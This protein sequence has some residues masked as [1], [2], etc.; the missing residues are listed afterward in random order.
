[1]L[2]DLIQAL[3]AA[4]VV[5]VIPGYPWSRVLRA[6]DDIV[7]QL[8]YA[9]G[10]SILLVPAVALAQARL[11]SIGLSFTVAIV[12][13][14]L[15]TIGGVVAYVTLGP[16]KGPAEHLAPPPKPLEL[17][18]LAPLL[19]ALV[20]TLGAVTHLILDRLVLPVIL[21]LILAA[22]AARLFERQL[23]EARE[24]TPLDADDNSVAGSLPARLDRVFG[25]GWLKYGL[26]A[27]AFGLVAVRSYSGPLRYDWPYL[28]GVDQFEHVVMTNMTIAT[29]T[30]GSFM[31]YPPGFHY[32]TALIKHFS[33][34]ETM[35]IYPVLGPILLPLVALACYAVARSL[36]GWGVGLGAVLLVGVISYGPYMHFTEARYP[37]MLTGHFI[38]VLA[39]G[40]LFALFA[41]PNRRT[42]ILMALMGSAVVLY[43]Q[44]ASLHEAILLGVITLCLL[45]YLLIHDRRRGVAIVGS[46]ALLGV[47]AVIFAWNTYD[48]PAI[49]GSALGISESGRGGDALS[50]AI[51]TQAPMSLIHQLATISHPVMW[52][53]LLG[54]FLLL[55]DRGNLPYTLARVTLLLWTLMVLVGS[56]T[57]MSGFPERFERDLAIPLSLLAAYALLTLLRSLVPLRMSF[58]TLAAFGAAL[59]ISATL[60]A[61]ANRNFD[62]ASG[63]SSE[64]PQILITRS[65]QVILS[66]NIE[67]AGDW[68]RANND[69]GNILAS[70]YI[71]IIP[72]RGILAMGG[73]DGVQS[74]DAA[75]IVFARDLPPFGA[76]PLEKALATLE[77]P[78]ASESLQFIRENDI[79]YV[80]VHKRPAGELLDF[81]E[82]EAL[83]KLYKSVYQNPRVAIYEPLFT[84]EES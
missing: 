2:G 48:L 42:G 47:L 12:S 70:P 37:N 18:T 50:M 14:L 29:G 16:A 77:N 33:G 35:A 27:V 31:L 15:V 13:V 7:E 58:G 83:E 49:V 9:V 38:L 63:P 40:A 8:A 39:M 84:G 20:L 22:G 56:R 79:R 65:A 57:A 6:T 64:I 19:A 24:Q 11:F 55:A 25:N 3:L 30:T 80:V 51:G 71:G 28:R 72:S 4:I 53:G 74:Y 23:F 61:Q 10:L 36:W 5:G 59:A 17:P 62:V 68:L 46:F 1:M 41:S 44:V 45:P 43:H 54:V 81:R 76:E 26:L 78:G 32:L 52:L 67:A 60:V 75:R 21:V 69:G 73:Y 66:P 34:L 82:Y